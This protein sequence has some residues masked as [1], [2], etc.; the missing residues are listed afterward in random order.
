[1]EFSRPL[2]GDG[3]QDLN[4]TTS[5]SESVIWAFTDEA[6]ISD[7]QF[8]K[9]KAAGASTVS[10][11]A[12]GLECLPPVKSEGG[13]FTS[14][15]G[16]Y[17][18]EWQISNDKTQMEV[19]MTAPSTAEWV[20]FGVSPDERMPNSDLYIG[21]M[22]GLTT[23]V[24]DRH[25]DGYNVPLRDADMAGKDDSEV[26]SGSGLGGLSITFVRPL[27]GSDNQMDRRRD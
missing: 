6:P 10:F 1:M 2:L 21:Y 22:D 16:S 11:G 7:T 23:V 15:D 27:V 20:G 26:I 18:A 24:E 9:H 17:T 14:P 5:G 4:I 3:A 13:S 19:T 25:A 12:E 8:G